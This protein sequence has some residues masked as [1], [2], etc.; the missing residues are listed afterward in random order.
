[1]ENQVDEAPASTKT[2]EQ[3]EAE[4][5]QTRESITEKVA[6]LENQVLGTVQSAA[7]T[8]TETVDAV[9]SF[10][11]TAPEAVSDTVEQVTS[12]IKEQVA[13]TFD[14]S[15]HVQENPYAC[16]GAS[17][18]VGFLAGFLL[19]GGSRSPRRS[20]ASPAS[21]ESEIYTAARESTPRDPAPRDTTPHAPG[22]FDEL[23]NMAA[24]KLREVGRVAIEAA[25]ASLSSTVRETIPKLVNQATHKLGENV[26]HAY[27]GQNKPKP[28]SEPDENGGFVYG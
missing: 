3:I 27:A 16:V 13:K 12:S 18:G 28:G 14:I 17:V 15:H 25:T 10:V 5:F 23:L 6:A 2:A 11:T 26:E 4:M 9:K 22:L 1:M 24:G 20:S 19:F 7:N 8:L 21:A